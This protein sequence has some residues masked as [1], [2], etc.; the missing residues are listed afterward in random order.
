MVGSLKGGLLF[1]KYLY[2]IKGKGV[3][4]DEFDK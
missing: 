1:K 4:K 2:I 3:N